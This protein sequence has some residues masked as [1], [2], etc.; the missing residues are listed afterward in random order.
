MASAARK[1]RTAASKI[2]VAESQLLLK[3]LARELK[4][5]ALAGG[6]SMNSQP[7]Q[8]DPSTSAPPQGTL[9]NI[10]NTGSTNSKNNYNA[11]MRYPPLAS[12][13]DGTFW[14]R[15]DFNPGPTRDPQDPYGLLGARTAAA[16]QFFDD[17]QEPPVHT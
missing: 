17:L 15:R 16:A 3:K 13:A 10:S 2:T 12:E 14:G 8:Q 9:N 1:A 11:Q 5:P 6:G 4:V 7:S